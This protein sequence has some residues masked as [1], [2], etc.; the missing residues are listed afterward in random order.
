MAMLSK[1]V[2]L[3]VRYNLK[4]SRQNFEHIC[5]YVELTLYAFDNQPE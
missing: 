1:V 4:S 5:H 2:N 3:G